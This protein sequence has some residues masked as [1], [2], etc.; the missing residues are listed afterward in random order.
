MKP[1]F[2]KSSRMGKEG[3]DRTLRQDGQG[4]VSD[5]DAKSGP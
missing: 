1:N 4:D 2:C 3:Q 5:R